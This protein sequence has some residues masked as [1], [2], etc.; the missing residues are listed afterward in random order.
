MFFAAFKKRA[1]DTVWELFPDRPEELLA[2]ADSLGAERLK[3][4][5][6]PVQIGMF[7]KLPV[8][9]IMWKGDDEVAG[10]A[11]V[12]FDESASRIMDTEDPAFVGS[13]LVDEPAE[14]MSSR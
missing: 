9:V 11:N 10:S 4:G 6:A 12:L 8:T 14:A 1:I 7:P 2:A 5:D 13:L 3:R